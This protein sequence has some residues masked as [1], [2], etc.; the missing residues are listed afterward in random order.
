MDI[1]PIEIMLILANLV[2]LVVVVWQF[3]GARRNPDPRRGPRTGAGI[4]RS[5]GTQRGRP[6]AAGSEVNSR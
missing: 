5:R 6:L 4:G 1:G 2:G 3:A